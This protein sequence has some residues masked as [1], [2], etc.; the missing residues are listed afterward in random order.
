MVKINILD[1]TLRDG[2]YVNNWKFG[3]S[4][5]KQ[6][7][8]YFTEAEIDFIEC[9]YLSNKTTYDINRSVFD[10]IDRLKSVLPLTH[11]SSKFVCMINLGEFNVEDIPDY[12]GTSVHGIRVVFHKKQTLH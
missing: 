1:C 6:M 8:N 3:N 5:I 12:D 7:L 4:H 9:G 2:G 10:S 11:H